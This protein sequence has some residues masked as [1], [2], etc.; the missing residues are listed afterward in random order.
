MITGHLGFIGS[1]LY[2]ALGG[3]GIDIKEGNDIRT[4][5]FPDEKIIF[6][7]AA[8]AS[9]PKSFENP[10]ESHSHNVTGTLRILEHA[11]K[12]GASLVFSSSSSV[13][14]P[15]SPYSVQKIICEEYLKLYW[16]LGVKSIALRYFNVFGERQELANDGYA[17][18]LSRFLDQYKNGKP[19][20][21]Y[22]TG[23]QRRDFVYVKDVVNANLLAARFLETATEYKAIDIGTGTNWSINEVADMIDKN[24]PRSYFPPRIEP[25]ENKSDIRK[26]KE[27]LNWEPQ[28]NIQEWLKHQLS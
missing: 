11:R 1:H 26:S 28:V 27:L 6:H 9:I 17:L 21:I 2:E 18:V 13:Y 25:F 19:F 15:V 14:D 8:Q 24:Y 20:T 4:C 12:I 3:T 7:C 10:L 16:K 23:K 22:G 5:A